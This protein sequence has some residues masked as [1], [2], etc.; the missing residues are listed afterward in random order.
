[1]KSGFFCLMILVT[2]VLM[3][4]KHNS[5]PVTACTGYN[6]AQLT[7]TTPTSGGRPPYTYQWQLN[8]TAIQGET[9]S[10]YDP[11]QITVAG[12]YSY[13]CAITDA[14]GTVV[15]TLPK[16]VT[17]VPDPQVTLSG[18]G[19]T[20]FDTPVTL[21]ALVTDGT[22]NVSYQW[23]SSSDNVAFISIPGATA[24]MYS[25][26]TS[27]AGTLFYRVNIFPAVG[28]CNNATSMGLSVIVNP[29]PSTSLIYHF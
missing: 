5:N 27:T 21:M 14:D 25:P 17:I 26:S 24:S 23:Q 28:S 20:C 6:P 13:N 4:G 19:I 16:I 10:S 7:F 15:F 2:L 9:L 11:P 1:M 18:G 3:P 29:L 8:N 12:T 22:G